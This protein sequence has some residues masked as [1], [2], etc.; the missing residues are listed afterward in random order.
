[1]KDQYKKCSL[2]D[3]IAQAMYYLDKGCVCNTQQV[4]CFCE[5]HIEKAMPIGSMILL[6]NNVNDFSYLT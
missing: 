4:Q 6:R 5:Y 2:C 1:M 3:S